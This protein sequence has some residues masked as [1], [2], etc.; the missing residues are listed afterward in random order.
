[1]RDYYSLLGVEA[2]ATKAEIKK[3]YRLLANKY[4]PDK[5]SDPNAAEKFIAIS[6][7]YEIL[8]NSKTRTQYDL[9]RWAKLKQKKAAKDDYN[10][11]VPPVESTRTR[12][13][14]EQRK[15]SIPYHQ[16]KNPSKKSFQL[17]TES[18]H[19]VSRYISHILGATI[20]SVILFSAISTLFN[21]LEKGLIRGAVISALILGIIYSIFWIGNNAYQE[22]KK[23]FEA[24]SVFYKISQNK[25]TNYTLS[26][27]AIVLLLYITFLKV[28]F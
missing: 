17:I 23:D 4:H 18:L 6:E 22:L 26:I 25:A 10:I 7:A 15:R 19:I 12:R 21:G 13:N 2:K 14:K 1:M 27:F 20:F 24:F 5:N 3:N 28:S 11:V 8:S 9:S 16:E